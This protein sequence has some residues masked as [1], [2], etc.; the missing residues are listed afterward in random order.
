M[1]I[2]TLLSVLLIPV[3]LVVFVFKWPSPVLLIGKGVMYLGKFILGLKVQV[4]GR[5]NVEKDKPY[6]FMANHLSFLDGPLLFMVIPQPVRVILKKGI[7]QIPVVG[8][9]MSL[10]GFVPVDRKGIRGGKRSIDRAT[11]R[12]KQK[13]HSFLIF[14]EGTRS[15]DGKIQS[16]RRGGFFLAVNSQVPIVPVTIKGTYELMPK[17]KFWAKK[18]KIQVI[19]HPPVSVKGLSKEDI[20]GLREKVWNIIKSSLE[21]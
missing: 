4:R 6:V 1:L 7:F 18:G 2:Y 15:R 11:R 20:S 10:V 17:G 13:G 14:P 19:F 16:F 21:Q 3:L 8:V 5:E 9:A 12:I